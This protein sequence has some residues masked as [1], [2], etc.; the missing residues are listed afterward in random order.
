MTRCVAVVGQTGVGKSTL[1]DALAGLEGNKPPEPAAGEVRCVNT[2]FLGER[3]A[4]L[5]CPGSLEFLQQS[6]DALLAADAAVICLSPDPEHAV[7]G[8]SYIR[9]LERSDL[10]HVIFVNRSDEA[11]ARMRD[12]IGANQDYSSAPIVLRQVPIREGD[13]IVGAVDLVSER[14]W[15]F[16]SGGQADLIEIPP[17]LSDRE[18]EARQQLLEELSD[19][20]DW[21]LEEIIEDRTPAND[22]VYLICSRLLEEHAVVPAFFGSA[23]NGDGVFRLMKA[24]RHEV[25]KL[26]DRQAGNG[27][28][29]VAFGSRHKKHVGK[30]VIR[31]P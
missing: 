13:Q 1:V 24:L 31:F 21:L 30:I 27:A 11:G 29:A 23:L 20:D 12:I 25:P 6:M 26:E 3:W 19:Y 28:T 18:Q 10:P 7:L 22:A 14:A 17:D 9:L 8:A 2:S 15:Q 16:Q 4:F 5:D